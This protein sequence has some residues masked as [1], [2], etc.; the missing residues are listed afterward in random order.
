MGAEKPEAVP[1]GGAGSNNPRGHGAPLWR[2]AQVLLA[3][4]VSEAEKGKKAAAPVA[5]A[6]ARGNA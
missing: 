3:H 2:Q 5:H 6:A 4:T 1:Q